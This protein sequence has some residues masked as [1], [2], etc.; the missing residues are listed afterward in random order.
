[1]DIKR[2]NIGHLNELVTIDISP[3][4]Y[5]S[6][7]E[8]SLKELKRKANIPGFRKG[9]V[10]MGMI[11][12]MYGK[13]VRAD[14][15]VKLTNDKFYQYLKENNLSVLFDPIAC[16]D[17]T[18]D[19]F[20]KAENFSFSFEIGLRPDVTV[21]Y[22]VAKKVIN[23]KITATNEEIDTEIAALCK[24]AGTYAAGETV[25]EED[26]LLVTVNPTDGREKFT[27]TITLNYV[28]DDELKNFIGKKI[29][30]EM[31]FD[32]KL[33]FKSDYEC[34]T[35]LKVKMEEL[36]SVSTEVHIKIDSIHHIVPSELNADFFAKVFP[37]GNVNTESELRK[38][39]KHQIELRHVNDTNTLFRYKAMEALVEQA[40]FSLPD[41]FIKKYLVDKKEEYTAE[42]IE[43][44]YNEIK[45]SINYQL[46]EE[47]IAKDCHIDITREEILNYMDA[48]VR[49]SY[50]G[51]T[52]ILE[53]E[54]EER[55]KQLSAEM[56][57]K[58]ENI[59]N[60]Y[61]NLFFE[62]LIQALKGKLNPK[63]KELSFKDFVNEISGQKEEKT[64]A[65]KVKKVS[66]TEDKTPTE[67]Q[68]PKTTKKPTAKK[69]E[70]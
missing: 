54:Q 29:G 8:K 5:Q 18:V 65:K 22:E 56:M 20:E 39:I 60:A 41:D 67:T 37:D 4:D 53:D 1:M 7:V 49:H 27:S 63:I 32:T 35:F 16:Q 23:Y 17:K 57:K 21:D 64:P 59:K 50:F 2:E 3:S 24:R 45:K 28:K 46:I 66:E 52:Q 48:Y 14:E 31:E 11:E 61:D 26:F 62:K 40:S 13:S 19:D 25:E 10:P 44:K 33:V 69:V 42:N 70:D 58:E 6:E 12:K 47:Q 15:I 43:E 34:S 36:K 55:V 51:T 9:M 38:I 68:K 30:D